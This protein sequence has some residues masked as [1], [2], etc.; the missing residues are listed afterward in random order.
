[1]I[2][3]DEFRVESLE[4]RDSGEFRVKS[5][6]LTP[7]ACGHPLNRGRLCVLTCYR[8]YDGVFLMDFD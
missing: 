6:E 3:F 8:D 5:R 1:M 7:L 4:L 2:F